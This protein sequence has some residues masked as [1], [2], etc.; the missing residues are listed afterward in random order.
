MSFTAERNP[1][2]FIGARFEPEL[3]RRIADLCGNEKGLWS[4]T[5]R[6]AVRRGIDALEREREA[7]RKTAE[8]DDLAAI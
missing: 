3:I 6:E 1:K 8:K 7:A 4:E 5:L 2:Q